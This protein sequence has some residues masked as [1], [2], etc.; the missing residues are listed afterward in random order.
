[1][2]I[3]V[4]FCGILLERYGKDKITNIQSSTEGYIL[5]INLSEIFHQPYIAIF[6]GVHSH[7][8]CDF[9]LFWLKFEENNG[10][11]LQISFFFILLLLTMI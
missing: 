2:W 7:V 5:F 1:M 11:K 3:F 9:I 4:L 8:F 6:A 10:Y